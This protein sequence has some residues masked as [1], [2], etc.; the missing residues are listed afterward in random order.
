[1]AL[2]KITQGITG[3]EA[4]NIIYNNDLE[5]QTAITVL[6]Q[7]VMGFEEVTGPLTTG[8]Y[9]NN[10][11]AIVPISGTTW[12]ASGFIQVT[13]GATIQVEAVTFLEGGG[14][15]PAQALVG[16]NSAGVFVAVLSGNVDTRVTGPVSYTVVNPAITQIRASSRTVIALKVFRSGGLIPA[17]RVEGLP[18]LTEKINNIFGGEFINVTGLT[19]SAYLND[20]GQAITIGTWLATDF[21]PVEFSDTILYDGITNVGTGTAR[22]VV[23]YDEGKAFH[24][25]ILGSYNSVNSG[26]A[27]REVSDSR[28]KYI[29]ACSH[30]SGTLKVQKS[31][32]TIAAERV[33][34]LPEAYAQIEILWNSSGAGKIIANKSWGSIGDSITAFNDTAKGYQKYVQDAI[35]FTNFINYG[36]SGRSL[37]SAADRASIL[38][39]I[40]NIAALDIYTLFAGTNDFKL[41]RPIGTMANYTGKTGGTTFYGALRET[42]DIL[43]AKR[44]T[45]YIAIF[46]PLRRNNDGYTSFST[47]TAGHK[48]EDYVDAL[49]AVAKLEAIT[50]LDLFNDSGLTDRNLPFYTSDGLHPTT[51]GHWLISRRM[52]GLLKERI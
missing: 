43:N 45:C 28:I 39:G 2:T 50:L 17:E 41:N 14:V 21:I 38:D 49:K 26:T 19:I 44:P 47:N 20:L 15:S 12:N 5:L 48:L 33:E 9:I 46:C 22:A 10:A 7:E 23:A 8:Q 51:L 3:A 42:V 37:T 29:R 31:G 32:D 25:I 52:L 11:G 24:S 36:F 18:E 13:T 1:M 4:S 30:N 35:Q 6:Q 16:Y 27:Q 34:G 40:Q